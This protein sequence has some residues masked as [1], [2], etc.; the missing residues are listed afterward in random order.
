M[1]HDPRFMAARAQAHVWYWVQLAIWPL[2]RNTEG[3]VYCIFLR[4]MLLGWVTALL[5][6]G[7]WLLN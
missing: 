1:K 4:G 2:I 6:G 5:A 7:I 3:C